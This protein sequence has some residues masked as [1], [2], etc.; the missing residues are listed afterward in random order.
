MATQ[1]IPA[2]Y[3]SVTPYLFLHD[4]NA[5]LEFYINAFGATELMRMAGPGGKIGHAEIRIGDSHVMLA[6][7]QP[8][9]GFRSPK[10]L[11]GAGASMAVYTTNVDQMFQQAIAAGGRVL[12][13]V[14]DQFYGDRSGTL[15]DP[16]GHVWT[17]A[18]H[19]E[20]VSEEEMTRRMTAMSQKLNPA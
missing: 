18:T 17:I 14:Q 3:H 8:D 7:E 9:M 16:F 19:I 1:P 2:G 10:T 13:E 20:D 12:R 6:D 15:E 5:A 4:A 11:G